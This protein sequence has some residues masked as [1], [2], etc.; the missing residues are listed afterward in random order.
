M[1]K[2]PA[3]ILIDIQNGFASQAYFGGNR[4][5]P[6]A[7]AQARILL[8]GFREHGLPVFHVKHNSRHPDSPLAPGQPGNDIHP[9]VQPLAGEPIL[10]KTVNSAFI[11]TALQESLDR[12]EIRTLVFAGLTTNHCVSTSVRMAGNL[13]Y[14]TY[15]AADATAC[16]NRRG[17]DG[18]LYDSELIHQTALANLHEEFATVLT[19]KD[20]LR[21]LRAGC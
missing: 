16:F 17:L 6:Q 4:N 20:I 3:L 1:D 13:G 5:N 21:L 9:L 19:A 7:E 15:L 14:T 8:D 10:E 18:T 11:G 2:L 12:H